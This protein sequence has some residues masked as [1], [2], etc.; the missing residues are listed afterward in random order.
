MAKKMDLIKKR[1]TGELKNPLRGRIFARD[2]RVN[3]R[4]RVGMYEKM[5]VY[6]EKVYN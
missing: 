1:S 3:S 6:W 2:L 5:R 4:S